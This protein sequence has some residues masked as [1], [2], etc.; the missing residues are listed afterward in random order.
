MLDK[1][2]ECFNRE[3]VLYTQHAKEEMRVEKFGIIKENEIFESVTN[4]EIIETYEEDKPYPSIL[5]FGRTT[6][7][8]PI[9]IVCAYSEEEDLAIVI[10]A[11]QP[12]PSRWIEYRRRK[13]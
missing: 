7:G 5:I 8:R 12:D 13:V 6:K 2:K 10:T 4:G 11:Y 3:K 1:I 9:H